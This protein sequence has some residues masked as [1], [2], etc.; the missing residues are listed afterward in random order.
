MTRADLEVQFKMF[1]A[2]AQRLRTMLFGGKNID[3]V[4][5]AQPTKEFDGRMGDPK[6]FLRLAFQSMWGHFTP[7]A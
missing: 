6:P 7:D 2:I 4:L 1:S 5:A 3:D